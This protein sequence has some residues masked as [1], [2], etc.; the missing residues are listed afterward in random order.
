MSET[1]KILLIEDDTLILRMLSTRLR[2]ENLEV[3]V[4]EDGEEGLELVKSVK[5]DLILLDLILPK[6]DGLSLLRKIKEDENVSKIPVL[7]LTNLKN[8]ETVE[9]S[10]KL[11]VSDYMVKVN[12][13]PDELVEKVKGTLGV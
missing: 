12:Y 5:P 2:E 8:D 3:F 1:K 4:A 6:L 7:I 9:E 11:G 13:T 10:I